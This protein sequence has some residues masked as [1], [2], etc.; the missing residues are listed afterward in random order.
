[1]RK[2]INMKLSNKL[3]LPVLAISL[4]TSSS[5]AMHKLSKEEI[6]QLE[7]QT[8]AKYKYDQQKKEDALKQEEAL[9]KWEQ[10]RKNNKIDQENIGLLA[11]TALFAGCIK[12]C[13]L[14]ASFHP[15]DITL[16]ALMKVCQTAFTI[17]YY[18]DLNDYNFASKGLAHICSGLVAC[19]AYHSITK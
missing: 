18:S 6:K 4:I 7:E 14:V 8:I 2:E 11:E 5:F 17:G 3:A 16:A 10:D 13:D 1:M 12:I 19:T 9:A 15:D